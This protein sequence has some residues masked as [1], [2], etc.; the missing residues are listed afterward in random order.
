MVVQTSPLVQALPS[1]QLPE[2]GLATHSPWTQTSVVQG[3]PSSQ[4]PVSST[5]PSQSSSR[6][7]QT[8]IPPTGALQ[9]DKPLASQVRYPTQVMV[10]PSGKLAA[11]SQVVARPLAVALSLQAQA[12]A[13]LGRQ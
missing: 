13:A 4:N 9:A 6:P 2:I 11:L 10:V 8:S 3:K 12:A 5:S 7:L 1:S